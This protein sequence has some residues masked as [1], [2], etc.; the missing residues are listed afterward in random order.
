MVAG[1]GSPRPLKSRIICTLLSVAG[2]LAKIRA[3]M[4]STGKRAAV[5]RPSYFG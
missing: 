1:S 3:S 5:I 4:L 2:S